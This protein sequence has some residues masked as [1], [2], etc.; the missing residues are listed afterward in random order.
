MTHC[1]LSFPVDHHLEHLCAVPTLLN[2]IVK[3]FVFDKDGVA[4]HLACKL[5][6]EVPGRQK[7]NPVSILLLDRVLESFLA[8]NIVGS[9]SD[10]DALNA[11]AGFSKRIC[12][13]ALISVKAI[14]QIS[15][16]CRVL[17]SRCDQQNS[18]SRDASGS[19]FAR[20]FA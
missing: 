4:D 17:C 16:R 1:G 3:P 14:S 9:D 2:G 11:V 7:C 10:Q 18:S 20:P 6:R 13:G 12:L 15:F 5:L 8:P 19:Q